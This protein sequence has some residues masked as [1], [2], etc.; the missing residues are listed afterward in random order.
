MTESGDN[1]RNESVDSLIKQSL[2]KDDNFQIPLD[3]AERLAK[4]F[5]A[6]I[7][8]KQLLGEWWL[9]I[10]VI[11]GACII[12]FGA[13]FYV[14]GNDILKVFVLENLSVLLIILTVVF[15][16]FIDQVILKLLFFR[17]NRKG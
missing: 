6:R 16:F 5:E 15:V 2:S 14:R 4:K 8:R 3:F 11:A 13:L 10:L 9:K 17:K 7:M 12:L 1:N